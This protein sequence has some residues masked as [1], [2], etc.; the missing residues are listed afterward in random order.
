MN[1]TVLLLLAGFSVGY[2]VHMSVEAENRLQ[3]AI[4]MEAANR[5]RE[6]LARGI[7]DSVLQVLALVQKRGAELGGEA[8][9]LGRLAGEQEATLRSLVGVGPAGPVTTDDQCDL[10]ALVGARTTAASRDAQ[11]RTWVAG[12]TNACAA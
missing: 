11:A 4:E 8:A 5:E 1:G 3:R 7:H 6:R 9:E 10:R 12:S 2:L